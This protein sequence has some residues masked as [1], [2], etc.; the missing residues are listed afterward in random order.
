MAMYMHATIEEL[1]E[2]M[3]SMWFVLRAYKGISEQSGSQ[4]AVCSE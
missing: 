4:S 1:L 3:F 2:A